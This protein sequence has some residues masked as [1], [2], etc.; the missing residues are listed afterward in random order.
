M[1]STTKDVRPLVLLDRDG[2]L[3]EEPKNFQIDSYQKFKLVDGAITSLVALKELGCRFV[4]WTNQDGLGTPS[5]PRKKYS[6]TQKLLEQ[7]LKSEQIEFEQVLLCPHKPKDQCLC[8]KPSTSLLLASDIAW[9][10]SKT[11]MIGDRESDLELASELKIPGILVN[12]KKQASLGSPSMAVNKFQVKNFTEAATL[13]RQL[14]TKASRSRNTEET[15]IEIA[16]NL[17]FGEKP[18]IKTGLGMFDHL[19]TQMLFHAGIGGS[20]VALGDTWID[21]H[22]LIEDTGIL[23]GQVLGD[24]LVQVKTKRRFAF[25][26][27]MDE[28]RSVCLIDLSGRF[29]FTF[30]ASFKNAKLGDIS[31][32]M[33]AHFFQSL[34]QSLNASV[35][36]KAAGKN[37]HHIGESLFKCV[38]R[39]LGANLNTNKPIFASTK[40]LLWI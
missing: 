31:T 38:G 10:A 14:L 25:A 9:N 32:E 34:T 30:E 6:Q 20:V 12:K 22:H 36:L 24:L 2:T 27:P 21:D 13:A 26:L 35:Y 40:G 17:S 11:I 23:L 19:I 33:I 18:M 4:L 28:A 37:D 15:K 5:Y 7:I 8:R 3:I 29:S 16:L 1:K 39:A